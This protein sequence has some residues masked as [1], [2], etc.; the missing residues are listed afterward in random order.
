MGCG[1]SLALQMEQSYVS[2]T[3]GLG[4]ILPLVCSVLP[5]PHSEPPLS[6]NPPSHT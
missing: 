2:T 3:G 4:S 6:L 5:C 1:C